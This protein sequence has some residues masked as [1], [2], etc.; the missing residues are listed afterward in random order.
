M[1]DI[2]LVELVGLWGSGNIAQCQGLKPS[3]GFFSLFHDIKATSI[4]LAD[5][6]P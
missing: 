5:G 4:A 3:P 6:R 1:C 2:I